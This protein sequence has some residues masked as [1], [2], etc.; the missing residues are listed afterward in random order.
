MGTVRR[1]RAVEEDGYNAV[2]W[3]LGTIRAVRGAEEGRGG[4]E[5]NRAIICRRTTPRE[6]DFGAIGMRG[7]VEVDGHGAVGGDPSAVRDVR[8][9]EQGRA[10]NEEERPVRAVGGCGA[11]EEDGDGAIRED[12]VTISAAR[13]AQE[14]RAG[15]KHDASCGAVGGRSVVAGKRDLST[16]AAA[17]HLR[18]AIGGMVGA[19]SS[20]G[21]A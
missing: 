15:N 9:I 16:V 10:G 19:L 3:D 6:R 18:R 5:H 7:A 12:V 8:G 4:D 13:R 2:H 14:S 21:A 20:E 11:A 1:R 17:L